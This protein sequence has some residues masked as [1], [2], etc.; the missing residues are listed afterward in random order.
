LKTTPL[1]EG[2]DRAVLKLFPRAG[3][4]VTGRVL[5]ADGTPAHPAKV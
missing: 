4:S 5:R 2:D 1:P 3:V